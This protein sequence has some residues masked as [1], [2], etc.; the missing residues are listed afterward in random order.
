MVQQV[1]QGQKKVIDLPNHWKIQILQSRHGALQVCKPKICHLAIW[2]LL[3]TLFGIKA[4]EAAV[5]PCVRVVGGKQKREAATRRGAKKGIDGRLELV[6]AFGAAQNGDGASV[7]KHLQGEQS[8][9]QRAAAQQQRARSPPS[10]SPT[11]TASF[12]HFWLSSRSRWTS[13][14]ETTW[15]FL[16]HLL[17]LRVACGRYPWG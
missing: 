4:P 10:E 16:A 1:H 11:F 13:R 8:G 3:L 9:F 5:S 15:P 14:T 7:C 6:E 12:S 2:R 17:Q